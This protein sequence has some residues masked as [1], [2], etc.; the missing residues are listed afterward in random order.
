MADPARSGSLSES[1]HLMLTRPY[2]RRGVAGLHIEDQGFPKNCGHLD[3][4]AIVTLDPP[5]RRARGAKVR[6]DRELFEA[7]GIGPGDACCRSHRAGGGHDSRSG[8]ITHELTLVYEGRQGR[9]VVL[10]PQL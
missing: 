10:F 8:S 7:A 3:N 9:Q 6:K 1:Q 2:E 4:K 5:A